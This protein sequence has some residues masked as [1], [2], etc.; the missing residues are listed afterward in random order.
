VDIRASQMFLHMSHHLSNVS[1]HN[2]SSLL[3]KSNNTIVQIIQWSSVFTGSNHFGAKNLGYW[4]RSQKT[5]GLE[6]WCVTRGQDSPG[7]ESFRWRQITAEG[8]ERSYQR[9]K[10]F[11]EYSIVH[12][13]LKNRRFEHGGANLV[14]CPGRHLT[15]FRFCWSRSPK[16]EFRFHSPDIQLS[17]RVGLR[18]TSRCCGC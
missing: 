2:S 12:L 5:P 13:L 4:S 7:A 6:P 17:W 11:L 18:C 15:S 3:V 14:S 8:A 9:H 10:H 1:F 16:Y